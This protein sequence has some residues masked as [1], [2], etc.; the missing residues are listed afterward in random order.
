MDSINRLISLTDLQLSG[1]PI[2]N[3]A[4]GGGRYEVVARV[5]GLAMLNGSAVRQLVTKLFDS[6]FVLADF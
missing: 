3:D 1:N 5:Q 4:R 2:L 6:T